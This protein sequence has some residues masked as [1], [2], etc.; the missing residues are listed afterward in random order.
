ML[1]AAMEMKAEASPSSS[2]FMSVHAGAVGI[3]ATIT[4]LLKQVKDELRL[5]RLA[6]R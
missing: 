4:K 5:C 6:Q 3:S 1:E 2:T